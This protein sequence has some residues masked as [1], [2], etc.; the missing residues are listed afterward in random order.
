ME[1]NS[2]KSLLEL[3]VEVLKSAGEPLQIKEIIEKAFAL[4]G[5]TDPR[6]DKKAQLYVDITTSSKFVYMG[7]G[8]WDLKANEPLSEYDKDGV[9]LKIE[10]VADEEI[11]GTTAADYETE[12]DVEA[13]DDEENEDSL[14]QEELDS[15]T[16][17]NPYGDSSDTEEEDEDESEFDDIRDTPDADEFD[18]DKYG[19]I[20]D[21]YEDLYDK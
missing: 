11:E 5:E 8:A 9:D 12:D 14:D 21:S 20:M 10:D 19:D 3:A 15:Y 7:D 6:G 2:Q 13:E 1:N 17:K 4:N 18:E 16:G